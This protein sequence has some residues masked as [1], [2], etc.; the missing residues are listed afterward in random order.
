MKILSGRVIHGDKIGR[1]LG[2]PTA[3][4]AYDCAKT[5][6]SV[7]HVNVIINDTLYRGMWVHAVWKKTFEVH[8]FDFSENIY[9]EEISIYL[10]D[11]IRENRSFPDNNALCEQLHKDKKHI[12]S[13]QKKVLTFWTFDVFHAGH[14]YYLS[15]AR[16]YGTWITTIVA[17][18][19]TVEKIKWFTPK[20]SEDT[21]LKNVKAFWICSEVI[22]W[23]PHD[24]LIPV[25]KI[26]PDII[27]LWYDQKSFSTQLQAYIDETGIEIVR[28]PSYKTDIYKSSKLRNL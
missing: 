4:I 1:K 10:L 16:R 24:P 19:S 12:V 18:D 21:R 13:L 27:C 7:F 15:Q 17:R 25:R 28:I 22:L 9:G 11:T 8:I 20:D 3:N 23:D 5:P 2:F 26:S 6:N 14:E